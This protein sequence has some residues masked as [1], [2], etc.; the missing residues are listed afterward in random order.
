MNK[1]QFVLSEKQKILLTAF[2]NYPDQKGMKEYIRKTVEYSRIDLAYIFLSIRL[3]WLNLFANLYNWSNK[4]THSPT[5]YEERGYLMAL[6]KF[7]PTVTVLEGQKN[8]N[9]ED[10]FSFFFWYDF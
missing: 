10:M 4:T 6:G 7:E 8:T 1:V 5:F 3:H 9:S 2:E